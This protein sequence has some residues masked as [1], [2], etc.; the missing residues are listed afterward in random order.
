[1]DTYY[2]TQGFTT[3][4]QQQKHHLKIN[5]AKH[6]VHG[7]P[8]INF[9][10]QVSKNESQQT[11]IGVYYGAHT[12]LFV[13]L[14]ERIKT[15]FKNIPAAIQTIDIDLGLVSPE[16]TILYLYIFLSTLV[17]SNLQKIQI[18]AVLLRE[19]VFSELQ[20]APALARNVTHLGFKDSVLSNAPSTQ[21][22]DA[23]LAWI[24]WFS[25]TAFFSYMVAHVLGIVSLYHL[26]TLVLV[27]FL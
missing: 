12:I 5:F 7:P 10:V 3:S 21:F 25:I 16:G 1:M 20:R 27:D 14:P 9:E 15:L 24:L 6:L 8:Y 4:N 13:N 11:Q 18:Q 22:Q 26:Q 17:Q 19:D 2:S 23:Y